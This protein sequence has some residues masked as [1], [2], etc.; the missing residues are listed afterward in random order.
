[1]ADAF[2]ATASPLTAR[3]WTALPQL[4][5]SYDV[6]AGPPTPR[7]VSWSPEGPATRGPVYAGQTVIRAVW[8]R[9]P[10]KR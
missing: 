8:L 4:G 1:M 9:D 10:P 2:T 7:R 6:R 3:V 5:S